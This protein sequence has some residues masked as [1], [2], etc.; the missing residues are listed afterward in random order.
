MA[1]EH[2]KL[3]ITRLYDAAKGVMVGVKPLREV[4]KMDASALSNAR[5][6]YLGMDSKQ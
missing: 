1:V 3:E 2:T 5:I 6:G 4:Y